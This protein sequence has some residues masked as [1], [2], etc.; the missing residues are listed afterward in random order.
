ML[1]VRAGLKRRLRKR[2]ERRDMPDPDQGVGRGSQILGAG[3]GVGG[4]ILWMMPTV[5]LQFMGEPAYQAGH[6]IGGYAYLLLISVL[7]YSVFSW[8]GYPLLRVITAVVMLGICIGFFLQASSRGSWGLVS[9][10]LN[11]CACLIL[12]L[13]DM[14]RLGQLRV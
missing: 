5:T 2:T 14:W 10:L 12:A 13:R 1:K 8:V 11:S 7:A 9:L 4:A 3:L 6:Y